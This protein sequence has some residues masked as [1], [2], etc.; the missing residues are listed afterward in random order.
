V[1][2]AVEIVRIGWEIVR[3]RG[4]QLQVGNSYLGA[5]GQGRTHLSLLF[6]HYSTKKNHKL[7]DLNNNKLFTYDFEGHKFKMSLLSLK[8]RC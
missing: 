2:V 8:S 6:S 3:I 1:I 7:Y 5:A 4:K